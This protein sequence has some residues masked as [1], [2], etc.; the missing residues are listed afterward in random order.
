MA[1][2]TA[3]STTPERVDVLIVTAVKLEYDAVLQVHTGAWEG[4]QWEKRLGPT[5]FTVAFRTFKAANGAPLRVAVTRTLEMGGVA[6]ANA[7]APLVTA[8]RPSCLAMCGVCVGRRGK[9]Q[10]GD[11]IIADRLWFYDTGKLTVEEVH[12]QRVERIQGDMLTYNLDPQ[13]KQRAESFQPPADI[14]WLSDRPLPY[15]P[16]MDWVLEQVLQGGEPS[17]HPERNVRCPDWTAV[18]ARLWSDVLKPGT[19]EPPKHLS[20]AALLNSRYE[21]VPFYEPG[22]AEQLKD[23]QQ[24]CDSPE[25]VSVRLFHGPGGMGKTRLFI[26]WCKRLKGQGWVT[27]FLEQPVALERFKALVGYELPK[28]VVIDYAESRPGLM[29]LLKEVAQCRSKAGLGRLRLVLLARNKGDWWEGLLA[30]DGPVKDLLQDTRPT[31]M[32]ALAEEVAGRDTVFLEA[33]RCFARLRNRAAPE[34]PSVDLAHPR[35][36]RVLYLHMAALATV[37]GLAFTAESLVEDVLEHEERFWRACL[38]SE[39]KTQ[40]QWKSVAKNAWR[41]VTALTGTSAWEKSQAH[42][43]RTRNNQ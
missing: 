35:F 24:W 31:A 12:G 19:S 23:L 15:E 29:E 25:P 34:G 3:E 26:E 36:D 37:E 6:A 11:V 13:W 8:Y 27:G 5:G 21:L 32:S 39:L 22:R 33:A 41:G 30:S 17:K 4:S 38:G 42:F 20:P 28:L 40:Q 2:S 43:R 7:A 18:L 9:V 10:L 14:H 16:Q 1:P